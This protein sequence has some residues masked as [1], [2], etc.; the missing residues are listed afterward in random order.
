MS[1]YSEHQPKREERENEEKINY[2]KIYEE[3]PITPFD[4]AKKMQCILDKAKTL[5]NSKEE[6]KEKYL[7][8][9][10]KEAICISEDS[11]KEINSTNQEEKQSIQYIEKEKVNELLNLQFDQII[12]QL[13]ECH[14][15]R[16]YRVADEIAMLAENDGYL[17]LSITHVNNYGKCLAEQLKARNMIPFMLNE[18]NIERSEYKRMLDICQEITNTFLNQ[19]GRCFAV[20][21]FFNILKLENNRQKYIDNSIKVIE[22]MSQNASNINRNI[23]L[24]GS[25][26]V[27]LYKDNGSYIYAVCKNANTCEIGIVNADKTFKELENVSFLSLLIILSTFK[28]LE[29]FY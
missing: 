13:D 29:Q 15:S 17:N 27:V 21:N 10:R 19:R 2:Q 16:L 9:Q 25:L 3:H 26:N 8:H 5:R 18:S 14:L 4:I 24:L 20:S 7:S 11:E 22:Y 1:L 23:V 6:D 28:S 12:K